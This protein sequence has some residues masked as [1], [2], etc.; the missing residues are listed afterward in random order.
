MA[1]LFAEGNMDV[2]SGHDFYYLKNAKLCIIE[3]KHGET[4]RMIFDLTLPLHSSPADRGEVE[5]RGI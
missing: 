1:F 4:L 2:D 5:G 3:I